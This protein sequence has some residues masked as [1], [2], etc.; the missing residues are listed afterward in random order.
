MN[1]IQALRMALK[2]LASSKLRSFLTMLG[3]IIGVASVIILVSLVNGV[4]KQVTDTFESMGTNLLQVQIT[5]RGGNRAV[6][7][8]DMIAMADENSDVISGISPSVTVSV[9]VKRG[10]ENIDT[11][12]T[13]V[14]EEYPSIRDIN[15]TEGRNLCYADVKNR[16]RNCVV[17]TYITRELFGGENYMG[18]TIKVNGKDFKIV[19]VVEETA[20][21]EE[22]SADDCL[23]IP[24]TIASKMSYSGT[25]N[26]FVI[27]AASPELT[28]EA[29]R[30][31]DKFM[32]EIFEST[33]YH[34][35]I[36]MADMLDSMNEILVM[37]EL[38][39]A[40]IAGISLLVGGV[41]IMNIMLVSVT[42]RT[43]EI[44]VRKS[45]GATPWDIKS[46]FVVE[47]IV[48]SS[49]GGIIGVIMGI[50]LS[51]ACN[52]FTTVALSVPAMI[53]SFSFSAFIGIAFGYFPAKKAAALNPI[54]AL[55]YD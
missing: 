41:G 44:G 22:G 45:L 28:A 21:G 54:D 14:S 26:S 31:I 19:G 23:Y 37:L 17:G 16:L 40:G 5:G 48:T 15:V 6:D 38:M 47:A 46:Q 3:I 1:L 18:Q 8:E 53:I 52:A 9:T 24:Y 4:T 32:Y 50:V 10:D 27:S 43:R 25:I 33:D 11:S 2:S 20:D 39:L 49:I 55:R 51:L 34:M 12:A 30:A 36:N 7:V 35:I 42:E 13:G 29:E